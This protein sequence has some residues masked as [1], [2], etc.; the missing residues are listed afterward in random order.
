MFLGFTDKSDRFLGYELIDKI[1]VGYRALVVVN[2]SK[3]PNINEIVYYKELDLN[4]S[5][6]NN[7]IF[8]G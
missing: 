5:V 8:Q 3:S 6:P 4:K 1:A 7:Y 2:T